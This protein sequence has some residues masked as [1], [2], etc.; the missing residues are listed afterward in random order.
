MFLLYSVIF[1]GIIMPIY[2]FECS[3]CGNIVERKAGYDDIELNLICNQCFGSYHENRI[4]SVFKRKI[5]KSN[6]IFKG[7]GWAKDN[8][9]K[10]EK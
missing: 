1:K 8:Y 7:D 5:S 10:K 9:C 2:D 6:I 4:H 3:D